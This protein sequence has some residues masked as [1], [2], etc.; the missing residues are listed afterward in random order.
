[1][2]ILHKRLAVLMLLFLLLS[3]AVRAQ[4]DGEEE[5]DST[6]TESIL[7][8]PNAFSP[9][10]DGIND[11]YKAKSDHRNIVDFHAYIYNRWGQRLFDWTNIEDGW[12]GTH[13]GNPV[14][15]GVYFVLV[16]AKGGDGK[17]YTIKRDVN[18]LRGKRE[19]NYE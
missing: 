5:S 11:L 10:G 14:K 9:N 15:E 17:T 18:L 8:M 7:N 13:R 19:Y 4:D 2:E 1:M 3:P 6:L 16:K 12:D